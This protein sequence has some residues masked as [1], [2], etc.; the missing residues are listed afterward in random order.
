M[1]GPDAGAGHPGGWL[2]AFSGLDIACVLESGCGWKAWPGVVGTAGPARHT[3]SGGPESHGEPSQRLSSP[4]FLWAGIIMGLKT[5]LR[6][7]SAMPVRL[8]LPGYFG[9]AGLILPGGGGFEPFGEDLVFRAGLAL[10]QLARLRLAEPDNVFGDR[11]EEPVFWAWA[12]LTP[13]YQ[14]LR[15]ARRLLSL[16]TVQEE[17]MDRIL[18]SRIQEPQSLTDCLSRSGFP[19]VGEGLATPPG[20]CNADRRHSACRSCSPSRRRSTSN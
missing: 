12:I 4:F 1:S 14:R 19:G 2:G 8:G 10:V 7:L 3:L 5:P 13:I 9:V 15:R 18:C 16:R 17:R 20:R 6:A 11:P